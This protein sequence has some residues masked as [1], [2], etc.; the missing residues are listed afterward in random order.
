MVA[1]E[2][3]VPLLTHDHSGT[4]TRATN[5]LAQANTHLSPDTD[6]G[7]SSLHHTLGPGSF[8][9]ASGSHIHAGTYM[10]VETGTVARYWAPGSQS[11]PAVS[12]VPIAL[13][14]AAET[15]SL[16]TIG[17]FGTGTAF[18]LKR[19]GA[20]A[21]SCNCRFA[22]LPAGGGETYVE[23]NNAGPIAANGGASSTAVNTRGV[24]V[25]DY[26]A[27]NTQIFMQVYQAPIT[28]T[29]AVNTLGGY[30]WVFLS[31]AWLHD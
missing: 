29:A 31:A 18:I 27:F 5:Q 15:T 9:A 23:I 30:G 20:W 6:N 26:F 10:P 22:I 24:S 17:A 1:L 3:N 7:P 28:G 14:N 25:T 12:N 16:V 19:A 21:I 11:I 2:S 8:Q 13:P 4:G